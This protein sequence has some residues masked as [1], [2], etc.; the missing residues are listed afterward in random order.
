MAR[1]RNHYEFA[2]ARA[3]SDRGAQLLPVDEGSKATPEGRTIKNFDLL[4]FRDDGPS[5]LIEIKGRRAST[6]PNAWTTMLDVASL[7]GWRGILGD[8]YQP[9]LAFVF[10]REI[11]TEQ[12]ADWLP[13]PAWEPDPNW[14]L[15]IGDLQ[16]QTPDCDFL[17]SRYAYTAFAVPLAVFQACAKLRSP[18]WRTLNLPSA[19][20]RKHAIP[21]AK[22]FEPVLA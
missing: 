1:W 12:S 21:F 6:T 9:M 20:F 11:E 18:R 14:D 16:P 3:L 5:W 17:H 2:L 13:D 19:A 7:E 15:G 10:A 8:G 4:W 22:W